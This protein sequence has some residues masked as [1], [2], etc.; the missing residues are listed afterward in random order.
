ME[1]LTSHYI[2]HIFKYLSLIQIGLFIVL[3]FI[4]L[5]TKIYQQHQEKLFHKKYHYIQKL[6]KN[7]E[8]LKPQQ[9]DNLK[10]NDLISFSIFFHLQK[11]NYWHDNQTYIDILNTLFLPN[12]IS[13]ASSRSWS[14]RNIAATILMLK[15]KFTKTC[16]ASEVFMLEMLLNDKV[17]LVQTN[18]ALAVFY[19]PSTRLMNKV[20]DVFSISERS[21]HE[22]L[23][24]M[25]KECAYNGSQFL[26][27]RLDT[28]TSNDIRSFCYRM[29][30]D[31]PVLDL[32]INKLSC[33]LES[34]SLDLK[35]SA[36][37]Y[38]AHINYKGYED[39]LVN[40]L[41]DKHWQIRARCAKLIGQTKNPKLAVFLEPILEDPVWWVRFRSASALTF[42]G[43]DGLNIL[44]AKRLSLDQFAADISSAQMELNKMNQESL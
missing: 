23:M 12:L 44:K 43:E 4:T 18:A 22:L 30:T 35:I 37:A 10:K 41:S 11:D 6:M 8:Q 24:S 2:I 13:Y 33:D 28:E 32:E 31:L 27:Y 25:M 42:L 14:L 21:Q 9:I 34:D 7:F 3:F 40:N 39:I 38:V 26:V 17:A 36:L 1:I 15:N 19:N 29:L 20:I 16:N 5:G